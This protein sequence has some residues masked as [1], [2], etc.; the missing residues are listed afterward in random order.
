[1][2]RSA[3]LTLLLVPIVA[4]AAPELKGDPAELTTYL[5]DGKRVVSISAGGEAKAQ[6]DRAIVTLRVKTKSGAFA[7]A[8]RLNREVRARLSQQLQ[9]AGIAADKISAAKFASVPNYGFFGDKPSSYEISNDVS[10]VVSGEDDM[11]VIAQVVDGT[12]EVSYLASQLDDSNKKA[13]VNEALEDA[14][15]NVAR[16]KLAFEK[17]L[18]TTL[19]PLRVGETSFQRAT[20]V[21]AAPLRYDQNLPMFTGEATLQSSMAGRSRPEAAATD[22]ASDVSSSGGFGELRYET[23]VRAEYLV[24]AR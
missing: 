3:L 14:L 17:A 7:Q 1:M 16:K 21:A 15:A 10:V 9:Q 12:K 13:H 2:I 5:I 22:S 19:T 18:G 4:S 24:Q 6:A 20:P 23:N 11:A 8:L